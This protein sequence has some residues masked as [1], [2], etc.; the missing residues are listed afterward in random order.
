MLYM[1]SVLLLTQSMLL[2]EEQ[3]HRVRELEQELGDLVSVVADEAYLP[4]LVTMTAYAPLDKGAVPGV[5]FSG[6]PRV[7]ASGNP[8]TPGRSIAMGRQYPY[9]TEVYIPGYGHRVVEDR[10]GAIGPASLDLMVETRREAFTVGRK[11]QLIF[12]KKE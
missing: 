5:C 11:E 1:V 12:I 8:S 3:S 6:D 7:T 9:G 4:V 10:G 2:T